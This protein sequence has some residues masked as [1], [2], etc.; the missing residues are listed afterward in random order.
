MKHLLLIVGFLLVTCPCCAREKVFEVPIDSARLAKLKNK[1]TYLMSLSEAELVQLVPEQSGIIYTDCPNCNASTQDRGNWRWQPQDPAHIIC[2]DCQQQFPDNA[3]FPTTGSIEVE[4]PNGVHRYPYWVR[5]NDNYRIYFQAHVDALARRHMDRACRD[6]ANLYYVTKNETYARRAALILIRFAKVYPGYAYHFDYP[7]REK[8]FWPYNA[9]RFEHSTVKRAPDRLSKYDW[10]RYY[11]IGQDLVEAYDALQEWTGLQNMAEGNAIDLIERQ[12]LGPMVDFAL[13]Y[14]DRLSN[15]SPSNWQRVIGAGR[16]LGRP[17]FVHEAVERFE[18][19]L[20]KRFLYDGH[21]METSPSYHAAVL[22]G[23]GRI[24][25]ALQHYTDPPGYRHPTTGKRFDQNSLATLFARHQRMQ[26]VLM[27]TRL[28]DG[29]FLPLNDTWWTRRGRVRKSMRCALLPG[30]GA[31][32]MGG[33]EGKQQYHVSLNFSSGVGHKHND[34]LSLGLFAFQKE[35]LPDLGYTHTA[36]RSFAKSTVSHNTV[37]VNGVEQKLDSDWTGNRCR[38]FITDGHAFHIAEAESSSAYPQTVKRYRRTLMTVGQNCTKAY[39]IDLFQIHGGQQHDYLLHG[40]A[41]EDSNI[42]VDN[43][44]MKP[45]AGTLMNEGAQFVLPQ[46]E[47]D[48]VG[49]EGAFGFV[50]NLSKSEAR[51]LLTVEMR[52][53][54]NPEI[55]IRS[56][57]ST[58]PNTAIFVGEAPSIRRA[59][60]SDQKLPHYWAPF[61]SVRRQGNHLKSTYVTVHEP[62][63]GKPYIQNVTVKRQSEAIVISITTASGIDH[64]VIALEDSATVQIQTS[65]GPL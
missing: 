27:R 18:M 35:L 37:V 10:W 21:W 17:D 22:A 40:S 55:G 2:K 34:A 43:L 20:A 58:E 45:F 51:G 60:S 9:E 8:V 7:F 44:P 31:A 62:F 64:A 11:A 57:L 48:P 33:G 30:L 59:R 29:R 14:P 41:D 61:F 42:R 3:N 36:W 24:E 23:I 52:L 13:D 5:P 4:A 46:G 15:L 47:S 38:A 39:V 56:W 32:V 53:E 65:V 16:V 54:T 63:A 12:L 26:N 1:H 50:R 19:F 28:P 6:L 25:V 49:A